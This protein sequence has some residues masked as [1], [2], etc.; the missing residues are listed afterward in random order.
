MEGVE[1][2]IHIPKIDISS[3]NARDFNAKIYNDHSL[4]YEIVLN[5]EEKEMVYTV[6]Y[7]YKVCNGLIGIVVVATEGPQAAGLVAGYNYY[8]YDAY[9]DREL[10]FDEYAEGFGFSTSELQSML[11]KMEDISGFHR[12]TCVGSSSILDSCLID[13]NGTYVVFS[14]VD[15]MGGMATYEVAPILKKAE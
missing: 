9:N 5:G 13:E 3:Q 14:H 6:S 15:T 7:D 12:H 1:H 8:Y 11:L 4:V 10:T 2:T